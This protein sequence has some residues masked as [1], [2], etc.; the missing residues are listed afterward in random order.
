MLL[1][2]GD[3]S[4][5]LKRDERVRVDIRRKQEARHAVFSATRAGEPRLDR[6]VV[7]SVKRCK[8]D[9]ER[10]DEILCDAFLLGN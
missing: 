7:C 4:K 8:E 1:K 10:D 9:K 5:L 3:Q 2:G 6:A